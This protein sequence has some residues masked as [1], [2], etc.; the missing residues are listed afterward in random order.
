MIDTLFRTDACVNQKVM[1]DTFLGKI[2]RVEE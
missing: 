1:P 2:K